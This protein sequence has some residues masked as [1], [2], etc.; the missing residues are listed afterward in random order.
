M[1][2][3][4]AAVFC[5]ASA[6]GTDVFLLLVVLLSTRLVDGQQRVQRLWR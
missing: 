2:M 1:L 3:Q 4:R 6:L 5:T